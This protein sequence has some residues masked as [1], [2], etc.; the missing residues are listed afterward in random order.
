MPGLIFDQ[1]LFLK[2]AIVMILLNGFNLLPVLPLDGGWIFHTLI[3]SRHYIMETTFRVI[4]LIAFVAIVLSL[5]SQ[6]L[7]IFGILMILGIP[8]A[9]RKSSNRNDSAKT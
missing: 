1:P 7:T 5:E 2:I 3:F 6:F 4:M 8:S 9:H